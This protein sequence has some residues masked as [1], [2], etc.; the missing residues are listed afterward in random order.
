M[1][2]PR[3]FISSTY[4][5]LKEVRNIIGTFVKNMGYEPVMHERSSVA[6]IQDKPL[7]EDCYHELAS[8]DIVVCIIGSKFGSQSSSNDLS[9]TM[10]EIQNAVKHKKKVYIF[11]ARDMFIENR[12]Y[13]Q[14]KANGNFKSAYTDDLRVHDFILNL[15]NDVKVHIVSSFDTTDEIVATLKAQFAGLFQNLLTRE[16]SVT[17]SKSLS[18]LNQATED[19]RCAVDMLKEE[20]EVFFKK[21]DS[22]ILRR[23]Y[24]IR[25]I[26]RHLGLRQAAIFAK[27]LESLDEIME[28][29]G[30]HSVEVD[31]VSNDKRK[32]RKEKAGDFGTDRRWVLTLKN[33]LFDNNG[34]IL[35]I[36]TS[37]MLDENIIWTE[38]DPFD[39]L[40]F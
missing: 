40:P 31:D 13:E 6:Y 34:K 2:A 11:I 20:N 26:E 10:N 23:N 22:T 9:I 37:K 25:R 29:M 14:N 35:D 1:A 38:E 3:V 21:F 12:T 28:V 16:A 5:D 39:D 30:F 18:D 7:E 19:I 36:P 24:T 4:Y 32:Y 17:E 15:R 8:C 33:E 27:D